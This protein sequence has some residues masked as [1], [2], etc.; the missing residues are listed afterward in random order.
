MFIRYI[1]L[2]KAHDHNKSHCDFTTCGFNVR[3]QMLDSLCVSKFND[4]F[5]NKPL[6]I[7]CAGN[8]NELNIFRKRL[9]NQFLRVKATN[10]FLTH[11]SVPDPRLMR[12][13]SPPSFP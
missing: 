1:P 4:N 3:K 2:S 5:I 6:T 13:E 11:T 7:H 9:T 12:C 10:T 8:W